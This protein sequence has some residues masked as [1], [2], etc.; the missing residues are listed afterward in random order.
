MEQQAA[1]TLKAILN[2]EEAISSTELSNFSETLS[3][4][5]TPHDCGEDFA[6]FEVR[7]MRGEPW[8]P[9][10]ARSTSSGRTSV[11]CWMRIRRGRMR[12]R[13]WT[14]PRPTSSA[15]WQTR[16]VR[17]SVPADWSSGFV[18]SGKTANFTAT[19]AKAADA[20]YRLFIVLSGVH[21][22]LRRQ[23]QLRIDEQLVERH[24]ARWVGL[25]D[26]H[27]DFGKPVKALP[28]LASPDLRLI[29]VVKK[30]VS[31]LTTPAG[32]AEGGPEARRARF[33]PHPDH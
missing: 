17:R 16:T 6:L 23:T 13:V 26:E 32:L 29:A 8:Y 14:R 28:L 21:N 1:N 19:I 25:T 7:R 33:L 27:R 11:R 24:P 18:Q 30:N 2:P 9:G 3:P 20:G 10:R 4:K 12:C 5:K 31:R 15:C 22:S